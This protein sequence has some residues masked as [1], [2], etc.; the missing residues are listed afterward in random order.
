MVG[1][2]LQAWAGEDQAKDYTS[3]HTAYKLPSRASK[4]GDT[5]DV[6]RGRYNTV[7]LAVFHPIPTPPPLTSGLLYTSS[8]REQSAQT[9]THK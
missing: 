7:D 1:T 6:A 8:C 5:V 9:L 2:P 4:E 3:F